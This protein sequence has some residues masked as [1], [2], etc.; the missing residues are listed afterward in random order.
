MFAI[1]TLIGIMTFFTNTDIHSD[2][3]VNIVGGL[4]TGT[5]LHFAFNKKK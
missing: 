5:I 4:I 2:L 3:A 1:N